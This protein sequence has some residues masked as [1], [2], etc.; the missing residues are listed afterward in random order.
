MLQ[1]DKNRAEKDHAKQNPLDPNKDLV[2]SRDELRQCKQ[3]TGH[4]CTPGQICL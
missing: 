2:R 4:A 3:F 1:E